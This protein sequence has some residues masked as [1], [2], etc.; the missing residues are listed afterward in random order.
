MVVTFLSRSTWNSLSKDP[1]A[2]RAIV[3]GRAVFHLNDM[4]SVPLT[5]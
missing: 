5:G 1:Y 3:S 4:D 2:N